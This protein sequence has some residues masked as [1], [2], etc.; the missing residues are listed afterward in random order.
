MLVIYAQLHSV[1]VVIALLEWKSQ[2]ARAVC[3]AE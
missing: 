1:I 3:T 2:T